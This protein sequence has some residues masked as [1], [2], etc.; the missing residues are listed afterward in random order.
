M[1]YFPIFNKKK[2]HK[3][4]VYCEHINPFQVHIHEQGVHVSKGGG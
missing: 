4:M 1:Y 3:Y 2:D